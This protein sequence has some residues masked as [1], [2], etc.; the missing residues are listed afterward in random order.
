MIRDTNLIAQYEGLN[1]L[2]IYY[3]WANDVKSVTLTIIS[4]L[5]DK[6]NLS[7]NN[8][9]DIT[10][11]IIEMMFEKDMGVHILPELL[12]RFKTARNTKITEVC[13]QI[14]ELAI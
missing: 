4:D 13:I 3:Q 11:K 14:I 7:K 12:K 5:L 2:L 8:F 9:K 6:I 1:T 10:V